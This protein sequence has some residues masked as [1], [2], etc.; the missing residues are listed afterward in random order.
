MDTASRAFREGDARAVAG[1]VKQ[2]WEVLSARAFGVEI[3]GCRFKCPGLPEE[4]WRTLIAGAYESA[5]RRTIKQ[6]IDRHS[7]VIE[8]GGCLGVVSCITNQL[9][10]RP[11]KHIV[12]EAN[13][14]LGPISRSN[15]TRNKCDFTL[16]NAALAYGCDDVKFW[17]NPDRPY[18][19]ALTPSNNKCREVSVPATTL[20]ALFERYTVTRCSL[21]C[22]IEGQEYEMVKNELAVISDCISTIIIET[23]PRVIG[24]AKTEEMLTALASAGFQTRDIMDD[25][26]VLTHA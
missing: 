10:D 17:V 1:K 11:R 3:D 26:Y 6:Y 21:V 7:P 22:D 14:E 5:E 12:L 8:L 9:L 15:A 25:V 4:I 24:Q 18:S 23:H 13:P 19:S 20:K 16:V 2:N